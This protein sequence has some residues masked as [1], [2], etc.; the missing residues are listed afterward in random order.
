MDDAQGYAWI[1][2]PDMVQACFDWCGYAH[3][4]A[5]MHVEMWL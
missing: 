3:I 4:H 1:E 2:T 5:H